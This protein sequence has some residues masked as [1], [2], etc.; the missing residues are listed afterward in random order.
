VA[1]AA[2]GAAAAAAA[3]GGASTTL[4]AYQAGLHLSS[5]P[6]HYFVPET[7]PTYWFE[8][9][10][11]S[12]EACAGVNA[13]GQYLRHVAAAAGAADGG[14]GSAAAVPPLQRGEVV[15]AFRVMEALERPLAAPVIDYLSSHPRAILVGPGAVDSGAEGR[16]GEDAGWAGRVPTISFVHTRKPSKQ[17]AA[18][19]Q[20]RFVLG[21]KWGWGFAGFEPGGTDVAKACRG[22]QSELPLP[23]KLPITKPPNQTPLNH[24]AR[25]F[26]IRNGHAYAHRLMTALAPALLPYVEREEVDVISTV[27]AGASQTKFVAALV[28]DGV[29]RISMLHYN[30]PAEVQGLLGALAEVL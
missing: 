26:A 2:G 3:G 24:Q 18:E 12:H 9:G 19:V 16:G 28:D 29:V 14:S 1:G 4:S 17:V 15:A 13:I 21:A 8:L 23:P 11:I 5:G 6:N 27:A 10:G 25:G 7:N 30:T 22:A 20:V